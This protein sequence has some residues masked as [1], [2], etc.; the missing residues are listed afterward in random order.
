MMTTR[1]FIPAAIAG[2]CFGLIA[3]HI[4]QALVGAF[5]H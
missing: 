3:A 5:I 1:E 4:V 2:I